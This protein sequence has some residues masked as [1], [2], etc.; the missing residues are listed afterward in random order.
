MDDSIKLELKGH[1]HPFVYLMKSN[2]YVHN[3]SKSDDHMAV[4]DGYLFGGSRLSADIP[5]SRLPNPMI[6]ENLQQI[7]VIFHEMLK[8]NPMGI[9][10]V[11]I[12]PHVSK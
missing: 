12:A 1:N 6:D 7:M 9:N 8:Q 10:H 2:R 4:P 11:E 5:K 3:N